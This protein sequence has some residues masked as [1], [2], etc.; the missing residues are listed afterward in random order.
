MEQVRGFQP[1]R[2][3]GVGFCGQLP[4]RPKAEK[5]I[6]KVRAALQKKLQSLLEAR[7]TTQRAQAAMAAKEA[8]SQ[9]LETNRR[10]FK[11]EKPA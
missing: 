6:N 3:L 9:R 10:A 1:R 11:T 2:H 8:S 7:K 4:Q 5:V